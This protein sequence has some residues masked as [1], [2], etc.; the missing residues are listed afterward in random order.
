[1]DIMEVNGF[2][3]SKSFFLFLFFKSIKIDN[4]LLELLIICAA[5]Q[6][7]EQKLD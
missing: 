3:A 1:M 4:F 7:C 6:D 5:I 2:I